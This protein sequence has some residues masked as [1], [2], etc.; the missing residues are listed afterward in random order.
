MKLYTVNLQSSAV[1]TEVLVVD[2]QR[3]D[4]SCG[5]YSENSVLAAH[6]LDHSADGL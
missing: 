4:L 6:Y 1:S 2:F 3:I 5:A